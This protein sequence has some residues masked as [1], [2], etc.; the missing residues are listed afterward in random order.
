MHAIGSISPYGLQKPVNRPQFVTRTHNGFSKVP[1]VSSHT[2][3][4]GFDPNLGE[5]GLAL[6]LLLAGYGAFGEIKDRR[7]K[8]AQPPQDGP[9]KNDKPSEPKS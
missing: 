6:L 9:D 8:P 7:S 2:P 3:R 5:I 4:F 1:A